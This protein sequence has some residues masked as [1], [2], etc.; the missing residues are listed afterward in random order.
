M[1]IAL[2]VESYESSY[3]GLTM[4]VTE[5]YW[6]A[7]VLEK[8]PQKS[9]VDM[10]V[11]PVSFQMLTSQIQSDRP[12]DPT[13]CEFHWWTS[14][15]L[16]LCPIS[17]SRTGIHKH[18]R[19]WTTSHNPVCMGRLLTQFVLDRKKGSGKM[20]SFWSSQFLLQVA[21]DTFPSKYWYDSLESS[22]LRSIKKLKFGRVYYI[23]VCFL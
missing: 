17:P 8:Q 18:Y 21:R 4:L 3:K 7:S 12:L 9:L 11:K 16:G 13:S 22:V 1:H 23:W 15:K 6:W 2:G 14:A 19:L 5:T 10:W 20:L